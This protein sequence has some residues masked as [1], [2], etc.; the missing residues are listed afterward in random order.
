MNE[1]INRLNELREKH[2]RAAKELD[3]VSGRIDKETGLVNPNYEPE[4]MQAWMELD[5]LEILELIYQQGHSGFSHGY[6]LTLLIPLL[7]DLPITPLTGNDWE[8]GTEC[9]NDQNNRCPRI[10]KRED[11]TAYNVEGYTFSDNNGKTWYHN[12]DSRKDITFPCTSKD[13]ETIYIK[14]TIF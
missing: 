14:K 11:G 12:K 3:L 9:G 10:F 13:L 4:E 8:W 1:H 5:V 7:E 2:P 6:M